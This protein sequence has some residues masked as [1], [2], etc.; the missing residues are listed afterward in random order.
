MY[1]LS[2]YLRSDTFLHKAWKTY[3][4]FVRVPN[5]RYPFF[6]I[7]DKNIFGYLY[8]KSYISE[9][10]I[11][12]A[13]YMAS[14]LEIYFFPFLMY[15]ILEETIHFLENNPGKNQHFNKYACLPIIQ[16]F[17]G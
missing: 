2:C 16:A 15:A 3:T 7:L 9:Q 1:I 11:V 12:F 8:A 4:R 6:K 14:Q 10:F 17:E 5:N 13:E